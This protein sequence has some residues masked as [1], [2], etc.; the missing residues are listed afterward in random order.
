MAYP[1]G[2]EYYKLRSKHGKDRQYPTVDEFREKCEEY[3][4][5]CI[6][7]PIKEQEVVK[8]KDH[9]EIIELNR[10]RAMNIQGLCN[11]LDLSLQGFLNY[12]KRDDFVDVITRVRQIIYTYKFEHASVNMMNA[13]IIARDLGLK[14]SSN[15]DHTTNGDKIDINVSIK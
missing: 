8:Y 5:Y 13:N 15:V 9:Y 10:P 11:W 1:K 14:D 6:E 12:E 3:I 2:N 4:S 7:N